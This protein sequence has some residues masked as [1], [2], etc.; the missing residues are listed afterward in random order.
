VLF[1][2]AG[3][4]AAAEQL[5]P[6]LSPADTAR[7][8][9]EI[10]DAIK[11]YVKVFSARDAKGVVGKVYNHPTIAFG[12]NGVTVVDP[13]SKLRT[14]KAFSRVWTQPTGKGRNI[15]IR[16]S[17][18]ST[19]MS[20]WPVAG[21]TATRRTAQCLQEAVHLTFLPGPMMAGN[22]GGYRPFRKQ[23]S[24]LHRLSS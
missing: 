8:K 24:D 18:S 13:Q 3:V 22:R 2:Y 6:Q 5:S 23:S 17:A 12:P 4:A 20:R 15:P 7:I 1:G 10:I 14:L 9:A 16:L 21:F 11:N 19:R